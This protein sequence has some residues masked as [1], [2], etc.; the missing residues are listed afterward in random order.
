MRP[1]RPIFRFGAR[2]PE[3][4]TEPGLLLAGG[5]WRRPGSSW[6]HGVL[7]VTRKEARDGAPA[8]L[9]ALFVTTVTE[10]G[11]QPLTANVVNGYRY[12]EPP[13][14]DAPGS[15]ELA[16]LPFHL[17][18]G[19]T[20]PFPM[21]PEAT[22]V[23]VSAREHSSEPLRLEPATRA[24]VADGDEVDELLTAYTLCHAGDPVE[25]V[26]HAQL[27]L[28][29]PELR[30]DL[31]AAH[32]YDAA[33][34]AALAHAKGADPKH[35]AL[36]LEWLGEDLRRRAARLAWIEV[37][38]IAP[39]TD[40]KRTEALN[41]AKQAQTTHLAAVRQDPDLEGLREDER[42]AALFEPPG[43]AS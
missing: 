30:H 38:L 7:T 13:A 29:L 2:T 25:A 1:S 15:G 37:E 10:L 17:D 22:W 16:H 20:L 35:A 18:L 6:V 9:R 4:P 21:Q 32:L 43:A 3:L 33:C 23:H 5:H 31:D 26:P 12:V 39:G 8:W 42:F 41:A 14:F 27:A 24:F 11:G 19:L 40:A 36:A 28:A 34:M